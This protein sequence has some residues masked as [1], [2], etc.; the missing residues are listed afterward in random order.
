MSC[1][2]IKMDKHRLESNLRNMT[3]AELVRYTGSKPAASALEVELAE[4][5]MTLLEA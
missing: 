2:E 3:D 1:D 5:L 4:R